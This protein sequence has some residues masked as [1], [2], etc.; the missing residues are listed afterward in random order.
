MKNSFK[1]I[2]VISLLIVLGLTAPAGAFVTTVTAP[3]SLLDTTCST[4]KNMFGESVAWVEKY[5]DLQT[6]LR[7]GL[8]DELDNVTSKACM[9]VIY[10][11][12]MAD[13]MGCSVV[14]I[15]ELSFGERMAGSIIPEI[16]LIFYVQEMTE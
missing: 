9:V 5:S 11:V 16:C 2:T 13:K 14:N 12:D 3:T 15:D 7:S 8:Q 10:A 6:S 1:I 4:L